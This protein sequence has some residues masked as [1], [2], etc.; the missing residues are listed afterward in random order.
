MFG[1]SNLARLDIEMKQPPS[2]PLTLQRHPEE[3]LHRA[4]VDYLRGVENPYSQ[5]FV[6]GALPPEAVL[7]HSPNGGR[8][9]KAEG[10]IFKAL[11]T[12]AGW[13][14]LEICYQSRIFFIELKSTTGGLSPTQKA[15]HAD[16]ERAG[17]PVAVCK[18]LE[19]VEGTLAGWGIPL[20]MRV[21]VT[22]RVS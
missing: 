17:M 2:I 21:P 4:V 13:P 15:C 7:H 19:E 8:R 22:G 1:A 16:L 5:E 10:G 18:S 14:D 9:S 3:A 6:G 11:G 12:H 20:T